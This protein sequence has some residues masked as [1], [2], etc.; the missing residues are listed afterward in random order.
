MKPVKKTS[1]AT[2]AN[3][4]TKA[5]RPD[6]ESFALYGKLEKQSRCNWR[7]EHLI[8]GQELTAY[9]KG[10]FNALLQG[11]NFKY[12]PAENWSGRLPGTMCVLGNI[13]EGNIVEL[14]ITK[15]TEIIGDSSAKVVNVIFGVDETGQAKIFNNS[16]SCGKL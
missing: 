2:K 15:E 12:K 16:L 13:K 14:T 10:G 11:A 3:K 1:K 5:I 4:A 7:N 6:V 8:F 9:T